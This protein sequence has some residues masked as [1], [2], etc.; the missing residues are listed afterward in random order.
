MLHV[1]SFRISET[2]LAFCEINLLLKIFF[3]CCPE[4]FICMC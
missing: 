3:K 4:Q 1:I 2:Y